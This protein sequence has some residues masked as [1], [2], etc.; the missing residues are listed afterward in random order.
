MYITTT[1]LLLLR[2]FC[3]LHSV[4]RVER[5]L[6]IKFDF[7][8]LPMNEYSYIRST[9]SDDHIWPSFVERLPEMGGESRMKSRTGNLS[10]V[11]A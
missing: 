4:L 7:S 5:I 10:A 2:G 8:L 9:G 11:S 6:Y 1:H 3:I